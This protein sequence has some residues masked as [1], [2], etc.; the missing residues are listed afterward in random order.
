MNMLR[1]CVVFLALSSCAAPRPAERVEPV[2]HDLDMTSLEMQEWRSRLRRIDSAFRRDP[3][4]YCLPPGADVDVDTLQISAVP[5][6]GGTTVGSAMAEVQT[7]V[8][9]R[10]DGGEI[11]LPKLKKITV[12]VAG[13]KLASR[14]HPAYE[15][16]STLAHELAHAW[17]ATQ[18][19]M[20]YVQSGDFGLIEGHAV[21]VQ[22]RW[23]QR[24]YPNVS[25]AEFLATRV[26]SYRAAYRFFQKNYMA[27]GSVDWSRIEA[28]E[29]R[30]RVK[31]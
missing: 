15:L 5:F 6:D 23:L 14:E 30:M 3:A 31:P 28:R 24:F 12:S 10:M 4:F 2:S 11:V 26:P 29:M 16:D 20:L 19:P 13:Y 27:D 22:F 25:E 7:L 9:R 8:L 1:V 18:Y 21:T 17:F